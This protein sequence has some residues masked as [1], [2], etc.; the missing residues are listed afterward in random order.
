MIVTSYGKNINPSSWENEVARSAP[1][2]SAAMVG[3]GRPY[4]TAILMR[5]A[6]I[7][8][9]GVVV[10]DSQILREC[11]AAVD[12][13]NRSLSAAEQVKRFV[14]VEADFSDFTTPTQKLRKQ[15]LLASSDHLLTELYE[16]H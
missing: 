1:I 16:G 9:P 15:D 14:L 13:A 6:E 11:Q 7:P 8:W 3:D 12:V 2:D 5:E 10:T 4:P